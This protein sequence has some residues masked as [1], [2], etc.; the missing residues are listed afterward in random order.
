MRESSPG[1]VPGPNEGHLAGTLDVACAC[2][3]NSAKPSV[4][5][6]A[7]AGGLLGKSSFSGGA[8]TVALGLVL[9]WAMSIIIA[10]IFVVASRWRPALERRWIAAGLAYGVVVFAV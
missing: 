2:L 3:I 8:A 4:I 5:L 6:Q 10:T 7:I 9:Q 1:S